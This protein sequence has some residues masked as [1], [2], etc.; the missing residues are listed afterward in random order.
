MTTYAI[1]TAVNIDSLATKGGSDTYNINGGYLTVDQHSR[2][3]TNNNTS[4]AMGNITLSATLGGTIEFTTAGVRLL[5]VASTGG[6]G[7]A[8]IGTAITFSGGATGTFMGKYVDLTSAPSSAAGL[9]AGHYVMIKGWNGTPILDGETGTVSGVTFVTDGDDGPG[10]LEIVGV[11]ALTVTA[12]RLGTFK[13]RGDYYYFQNVTTSGSRAT[14]YQIPTTGSSL[15]YV[16]SIEVE[17]GVGTDEYECYPNAGSMTALLAN[18]ATDAVRGKYCW[19]STGGLVRF[20]HDG[21]NSTGGYLPDSGLKIRVPNIFFQCCTAAAPTAN[22]LPHA[23]PGTRMEFATTGG[24]VLDIQRASMNWY[25]NFAQPYSVTLSG[26]GTFG[27]IILTE[28]ATAIAWDHVCVG[29]EAANTQLALTMGLNFAGGTLT[30]CVFSRSA[31]GGSGAYV[32]SWADCTGF[33][34]LRTKYRSLTKAANATTGSLT[35][36]R[37]QNSTFT[38]TTLGGGR[39]LAT[40]CVGTEFYTT[41]YYDHPATTTTTGMPMYAFDLATACSDFW[42]DG[43]DF[44]GL[45]MCQPYS[46]IMQVGAAACTKIRLRNIGTSAAPLDFGG[47]RRDAQAWTRVTTTATLTTGTAHG[48]KANDII[49]V[50]VSSDVAAITVAAKTVLTAPTATTLTF[51]C[52]NGGAASGTLSYYPTMA[53]TLIAI[54]NGAAASD[55]KV[56]RCYATNNRSAIFSGDN[57]SKDVIFESVMSDYI[58]APTT[59]MLYLNV[60]GCGSTFGLAAQTACYGTNWL[61]YFTHDITPNVAAQAWTRTTTTATVTSTDHGLRTG[62]FINV[63]TTSDAAAIVKGQKTVTVLTKDTFTFTC[64]NAGAASGTLTF[65]TLSD[66]IGILM[67]ET[68]VL[69]PYSID[70][71]V[72]AFTSAGSLNM[73]AV[74]DQV[75][76][77]TPHYFLEHTGFPLAE[78]VM[79]G[80]VLANYEITYALDRNDGN[81]F[82]S[83]KNLSYG[84]AGGG[85]SNAST[86]VTMTSTTGVAVGDYVWGTN[87][88]PNAKVS[89]ITNGTTIVVDTANIG[90]VSGILRFNQL[91][92]EAAISAS[93]FKMKVRLKCI[94]GSGAAITSLYIY[95]T[96][97]ATS[98]AAQYPLDTFTLTLTGLQTGSDVVVYQAGTTT[99]RESVDAVSS[100]G[101]TYETPESIDIGV[102]KAGYIP[103]YIRGFALASASASLPIAQVADRAYLS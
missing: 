96:S 29:Q 16:P 60:K 22:V 98:R 52:L 103:F 101:Y 9:S 51:T 41:T 12:N 40:T 67:N 88:A 33:T 8:A 59:A 20:G 89:S 84:R 50:I 75:T 68:S 63:G 78:V 72:A 73:A 77:T 45:T 85:G 48:L 80:G 17:T 65:Q 49:Y 37:V 6:G 95:A 11:D 53:A 90:T 36:T 87:I 91:P 86:N 30:D 66:R 43:V 38:D 100:Y 28:C 70:A 24:G 23:T 83:F 94:T 42:V 15:M 14:T 7:G 57:S 99:V 61:N 76:F 44:G 74:N 93:G 56:Q 5:K 62:L 27:L 39:V 10:W 13:V 2:Y 21:T 69:A 64:L 46:G 35:M 55:V 92:S 3:G 4:A 47:A 82:G 79:G 1:T 25:M 34:C 81:G 102:F 18:V 58:S 19:I 97:D 32:G 31:Q 54:A 71:G 26:V